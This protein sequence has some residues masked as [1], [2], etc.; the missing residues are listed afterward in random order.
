[1]LMEALRPKDKIPAGKSIEAHINERIR[2]SE[3]KYFMEEDNY[4]L[5][6][7]PIP[8]KSNDEQ[9]F[10]EEIR[11]DSSELR[12]A[13]LELDTIDRFVDDRS[14]HLE[15][16]VEKMQQVTKTSE[17]K[18]LLDELR[19]VANDRLDKLEKSAGGNVL[20]RR[21]VSAQRQ[22]IL[23]RIAVSESKL[24]EL[25]N[26]IRELNVD[27]PQRQRA[28]LVDTEII[29]MS[30]GM[31]LLYLLGGSTLICGLVASSLLLSA[32]KDAEFARKL[33]KTMPYTAGVLDM[34]GLPK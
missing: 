17:S 10:Q 30:S 8:S 5:N 14:T 26:S 2:S 16:T 19:R 29:Q 13:K 11:Q 6:R 18:M 27:E 22:R 31:W 4:K 28:K 1:M 25:D 20:L 9:D 21:Q 7:N 32:Q 15:S 33:R 23:D 24:N 3:A 34:V 12:A